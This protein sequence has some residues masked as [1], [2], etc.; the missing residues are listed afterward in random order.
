MRRA[1]PARPATRVALAALATAIAAAMTLGG[2]GARAQTDDELATARKLFA[3][4]VADEDANRYDTAL[5]KFRRVAAVKETA[6][7]RYRIATCLEYLGHRA[8]ALADYATAVRLAETEKNGAEVGREASA[9][10]AQLDRIVP[11]L[12]V[13]LPPDAPPDTQVRIDDQ[14]MTADALRNP[15]VLDTGNHTLV[16]EA[17]GRV[18][19]HTGVTLPEGGSVRITVA[20][21][22]LGATDGGPPGDAGSRPIDQQGTVA[23]LSPSPLAIGLLG[24]GG[25]LA[26]GSI[27]SF[28]LRSSNL[29]TMTRDCTLPPSPDGT[30][31]CPR[32]TMNDVNGARS[33]ALTEGPLGWGLAIGAV[34]ALGAGTWLLLSR[35]PEAEPR[36][37]RLAP[38]VSHQGGMLVV[39]GP[40]PQ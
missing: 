38:V 32:R 24:L 10:A 16:A 39:S 33:A 7:V 1:P 27:V 31:N 25:A 20:L 19:Y 29:D 18:P 23:G 37:V 4:A 35:H 22:P 8:Q 17:A 30:L 21:E 28:A 3:E 26:I 14:P 15:I 2:V 11:H 6:N 13:V 5:E 12:A 34:G 40:L 9:R 36:A